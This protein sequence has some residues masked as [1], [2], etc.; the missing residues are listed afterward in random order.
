MRAWVAVEAGLFVSV[1]V[2]HL[3]F[4]YYSSY[5]REYRDH[6]DSSAIPVGECG[7]M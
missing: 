5:F 3:V 2:T 7:V 6:T 1:L 4:L